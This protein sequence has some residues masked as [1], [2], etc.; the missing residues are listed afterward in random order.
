MFSPTLIWCLF[1]SW[2][3]GLLIFIEGRDPADERRLCRSSSSAKA[4]ARSEPRSKI[5]PRDPVAAGSAAGSSSAIWLVPDCSIHPLGRRRAPARPPPPRAVSRV[6][7][8]RVL[9]RRAD[10]PPLLDRRRR[11]DPVGRTA[12]RSIRQHVPVLLYN[13]QI[14]DL[15]KSLVASVTGARLFVRHSS[16]IIQRAP[17]GRR[18]RPAPFR[19]AGHVARRHLLT[20]NLAENRRIQ[21]GGY[22][23][24]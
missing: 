9:C 22:P 18:R 8:T 23:E 14:V 3:G 17:V 11:C 21:D 1:A 7:L 2:S 12:R 20:V 4:R 13:W 24:R 15:F 16:R 5:T 6:E 10:T 19:S